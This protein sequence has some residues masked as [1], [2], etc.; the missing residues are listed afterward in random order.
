MQAIWRQLR[1]VQQL[2]VR[3]H[4]ASRFYDCPLL[5]SDAAP[6]PWGPSGQVDAR[7]M[8]DAERHAWLQVPKYNILGPTCLGGHIR[9]DI[10]TPAVLHSG[11]HSRDQ[12]SRTSPHCQTGQSK[13][14]LYRTGP[15]IVSSNTIH[16]GLAVAGHAKWA[17]ARRSCGHSAQWAHK[18]GDAGGLH[19]VQHADAARPSLRAGVVSQ[20]STAR[21]PLCRQSLCIPSATCSVFLK[22]PY[23]DRRVTLM[24]QP[25]VYF[26]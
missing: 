21:F 1:E 12:V 14:F 8:D 10:K 2:Q 9:A 3:R 17:A 11:M 23:G 15:R 18:A 19:A 24:R 26:A 5:A 7:E 25:K 16:F 6:T 4:R 13:G 20:P 22:I